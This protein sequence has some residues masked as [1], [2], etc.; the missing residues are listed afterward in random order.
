M[1]RLEALSV[2]RQ[3][4]F[5]QSVVKID[6]FYGIEIDDFATEVAILAL[7]IAKHQMDQEFED[8]FGV[9]LHMI[10]LRSMA[11]ITCANA[12]RMD[13]EKICPHDADDEVYLIGKRWLTQRIRNSAVYEYAL[14]AQS[15]ITGITPLLGFGRDAVRHLYQAFL[16]FPVAAFAPSSMITSKAVKRYAAASISTRESCPSLFYYVSRLSGTARTQ[17]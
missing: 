7:W 11:Q 14:A 8:K 9:T 10:P 4:L 17:P 15:W 12:T 5:E 6:N 3:T 16:A 2:K 13:W 1:Q